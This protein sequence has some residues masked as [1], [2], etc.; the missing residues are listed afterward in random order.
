MERN[1]S[2]APPFLFG[3]RIVLGVTGGV[4]AY[5]AAELVR[6]LVQTGAQVDVVLTPG[7]AHFVTPTTFQALS[8][9]PVWCD[10]WDERR[11]NAMAH[12][13]LTRGADLLLVA[14]CTADAMARF[15]QGQADD[16]LATLA[17]AR[18]CPMAVAPAM[19]RQMWLHPATQR[20][21]AQLVADG[22]LFWGPAEGEQA[23]GEIGPGRMI[24]PDE[25]VA[26]LEAF[27]APKWFSGHAVLVTAG[28]TYEPLDP[29]RVLTNLSSGK[30]GYALAQAF[31]QAGATVTLVSG[32]VSLPTPWGVTR[33]DVTTAEEMR[34]AVLERVP[35]HRI[36]ASVAA[37]A[38]YRPVRV[39]PQ[40]I[41]KGAERLTLELVRNPDILAEVAALPEPPWCIGFA[42]ES[43]NLDEYAERKRREKGLQ[44][45]V[46][47]LV[48][49]AMGRDEN[50][51]V[52]YDENGR[53]PLPTADKAQVAWGIVRHVARRLGLIDTA[54]E[55]GEL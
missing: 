43:E 2:G 26:R 27:F 49:E 41:K 48:Q 24:E 16:L 6:R 44:L 11:A 14:P 9:R 46:G 19:N 40:K 54:V 37:V 30:M 35:G 12:I 31:A 45:V 10:P 34:T 28:P 42:A 5:K 33:V 21:R 13:D 18:A 51:V 47:N 32:P 39:S 17:L 23:C 8:G 55:R 29:V 50:T 22:V 53:I 36:F 52:L 15:A 1:E 38:D 3:R 4:A 7:G 20:N 25:I